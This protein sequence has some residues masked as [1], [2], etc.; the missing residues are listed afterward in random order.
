MLDPRVIRADPERVREGL[1]KKGAEGTVDA[2]LRLDEQ[3][4]RLLTETESLKATLNASSKEIGALKKSGQDASSLMAE[5][6]ALRDRIKGLDGEVAGADSELETLALAIPNLPHESVPVGLEEEANETIRESGE[7]Q[8]FGFQPRPHFELGGETWGFDFERATKITGVGGVGFPLLWGGLAK[9][10]RALMQ[11]ALDFHTARGYKEIWAPALAGRASMTG[12]GQLPKFEEDMYHVPSDDLFLIPTAE[13]PLTNYHREEILD[14]DQLPALFTGYTPC[15]RREAG[16]A[17]KD[18][19]GL[20]RVH[21]FDKVEL[22]KLTRPEES[23]DHLE[24]LTADAE[25]C[26]KALGLPV[27]IVNLSTDGISFA[28]AKTYD[29]EVYAPGVDKWL[30]VSSCSNFE[31]FQARRA[32]IRYRPE[33]GAKPEFVHTLNGSGM[34]FPRILAALLEN[35]QQEDGSVTLPDVLRPYMG[36]EKL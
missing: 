1:A 3:R 12:T 13:V 32:N 4:R 15:F 23:Y 31:A 11:Y 18:T 22:V 7:I 6:A 28:S 34:A 19:R 10:T 21:Q 2:F 36:G 29:L 9:L 8:T 20:L 33:R 16:S 25:A 17:G 30:E 5:M 35:Y 24:S 14:A 27:R 26:V